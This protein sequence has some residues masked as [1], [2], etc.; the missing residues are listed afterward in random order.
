MILILLGLIVLNGL[1]AM[2][3]MALVSSR[4]A[5]LQMHIDNGDRGAIAAAKL[6]EDPSSFLSTVQIGITSISILSGIFGEAALAKP[7][8]VYLTTYGID[9]ATASIVSTILVVVLVTYI[10]IVVGELAPK[11]L[12]QLNPEGVARIVA[13]PLALLSLIARPLVIFLSASTRFILRLMG[14]RN[15]RGPSVTQEEIHAL[16]VEGSE[17]GLIDEQEHQMVRNVFRL[18]DR[19]IVSLMVPRLDVTWLSVNDSPDTIL[20][21]IAT[22]QYSRFPVCGDSINDVMGLVMAKTV[23]TQA[24]TG[25][26]IDLEKIMEPPLYVPE[27]LNGMELLNALRSS[28]TEMALV[29]DEYGDIQGI[30]TVQDLLEA[31]T[32]EFSSSDERDAWAIQREDGSWLFDGLIPN[33]DLK[34]RLGLKVLPEQERGTYNTLSGLLMLQLGRIPQTT[35]VVKW[36]GWR[37]EIVDMDGKR[38]DKVLVSRMPDDD[39]DTDSSET[40]F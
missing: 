20:E 23:L 12:G 5:R 34:D 6:A 15:T 9:V 35:D 18:D 40:D 29:V 24:L 22:S 8:A 17:S 37:F 30:V 16:L 3:E 21:K 7:L 28:R 32:G 11:R 2:S 39:G 27:S 4:K 19:K 10:S 31:I 38:I 33:D 26:P 36:E 14:V 25:Q 1:F 13:R